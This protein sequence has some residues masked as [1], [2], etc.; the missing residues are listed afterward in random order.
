M[1]GWLCD[2]IE[3][4]SRRGR[5]V[6]AARPTEEVAPGQVFT[7]FH[8]PAA[9]ANEL[10]SSRAEPTPSPTAPNTRSP[11]SPCARSGSVFPGP[12]LTRR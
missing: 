1:T 3:I 5:M 4:R 11:P 8:F 12:R 9:P 6:L 2:P 7:A 10:T